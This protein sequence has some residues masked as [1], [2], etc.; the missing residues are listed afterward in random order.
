MSKALVSQIMEQICDACGAVKKWELV[1]ADTNEPILAEMQEWYVVNRKVI[2]RNPMTGREELTTIVADACSMVCVP[3]AAVKLALP[4]R[5][6]E[7]EPEN[8]ID[9]ASL[10]A[11]NFPQPN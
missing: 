11:A 7:P 10:R 8:E 3:A 6:A 2:V 1:G 9:L 5:I 4:P